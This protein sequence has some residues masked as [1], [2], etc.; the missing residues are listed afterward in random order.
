VNSRS[1]KRPRPPLDQQALD[2]LA[3][4]YVGRYAT[5]R[6]KLRHYL[7]RK[8]RE[9]GWEGPTGPDF[10]TLVNR[11]SARGYVDDTAF[12]A[13]RSASLQRRGYGERRIA[14]ALRAAGVA[15]E[16]S[17]N[18][19]EDARDKAMEIAVH[20]ARRRRL[21]PFS[22]DPGDQSARNKAFA[23]MARAGHSPEVIRRV[24]DAS[25]AELADPDWF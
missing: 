11:F 13:A 10:D 12:A 19:R 5:T 22:M 25:P 18:A 21:G 15:E 16:D 24:L 23:A 14:Q 3:L 9:R 20:F 2:Q 4:F 8:V 7:A 1:H 17:G 6:A